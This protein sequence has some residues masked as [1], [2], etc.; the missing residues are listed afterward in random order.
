MCIVISMDITLSVYHQ[1]FFSDTDLGIRLHVRVVHVG[2]DCTAVGV[3][4]VLVVVI[5]V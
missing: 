5:I 1:A 2:Y 3:I 4:V